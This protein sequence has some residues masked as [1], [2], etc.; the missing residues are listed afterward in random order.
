[1]VRYICTKWWDIFVFCIADFC[2]CVFVC[3]FVFLFAKTAS[4]IF[5][6]KNIK[7]FSRG[8]VCFSK[9]DILYAQAPKDT[10]CGDSQAFIVDGADL[11]FVCACH[12]TS[13]LKS[14]VIFVFQIHTGGLLPLA[15]FAK[16]FCPN[17][18]A[19]LPLYKNA[20][21]Q[22]LEVRLNCP[23]YGEGYKVLTMDDTF[24]VETLPA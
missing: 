17:S 23:P 7:M 9:R 2:C 8:A 21:Y 18:Y 10:S 15:A 11:L 24:R 14:S 1:M 20:I 12:V 5:V 3:L 19:N 16:C 4:Y 13:V 6:D 22:V